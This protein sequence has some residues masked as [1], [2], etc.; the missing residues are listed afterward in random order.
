MSNKVLLVLISI[1]LLSFLQPLRYS[2]YPSSRNG[3]LIVATEP[4]LAYIVSEMTIGTGVTV[5]SIVPEGSDPHSYPL[6]PNDIQLIQSANLLVL[7]AREEFHIEE[8]IIE[9]KNNA[10]QFL[11]FENYSSYGAELFPTV[12]IE[13]NYH[14]YWI[15]PDNAL[16]I[17]KALNATLCQLDP[18][19]SEIYSKNLNYFSARLYDLKS[20]ISKFSSKYKLNGSG[21]VIAIACIAYIPLMLGMDIKAMFLVEPEESS[22]SGDISK[23]EEKIRTGEIKYIACP[24]SMKDGTPGQI[25]RQ[26]SKDT[27]APIIYMDSFSLSGTRG[28][29]SFIS[30][31]LGEIETSLNISLPESNAVIYY[32]VIALLGAIVAVEAVIIFQLR[33]EAQTV[34]QE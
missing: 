33:R 6:S 20:E 16:A 10:T 31:I 19:N 26:V 24:L 25:S 9:N 28:Y 11:D 17:A 7:G 18:T 23:I 2:S 30:R 34:Q 22:S 14:G 12:T 3:L 8:R 5:N 21:V 27:G 1:S 29:F 13:K 15:Y 32:I 4:S